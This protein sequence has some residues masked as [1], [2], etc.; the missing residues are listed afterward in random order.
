MV[1]MSSFMLPAV[2]IARICAFRVAA[3]LPEIPA[4]TVPMAAGEAPRTRRE[5]YFEED[6]FMEVIKM[7]ENRGEGLKFG[8]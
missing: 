3:M 6:I 7:E 2:D 8:G 4:V 5:A 1:S